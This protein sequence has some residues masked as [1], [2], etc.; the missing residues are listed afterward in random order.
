LAW[1]CAKRWATSPVSW[2][3][4]LA[5]EAFDLDRQRRRTLGESSKVAVELLQLEV[6]LQVHGQGV[7][8]G[9]QVAAGLLLTLEPV[10]DRFQ[11][12]IEPLVLLPNRVGGSESVGV[13]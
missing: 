2:L 10:L 1:N 6:R 11:E 12:G 8:Q 13:D 9:D 4:V 7:E 3:N 5:Q